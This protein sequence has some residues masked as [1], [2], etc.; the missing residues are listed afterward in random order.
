MRRVERGTSD[1]Q[2]ESVDDNLGPLNGANNIAKSITIAALPGQ[3]AFVVV[4]SNNV[5]FFVA[6]GATDSITGGE[7]SHECEYDQHDL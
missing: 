5:G 4:A 2:S 3:T 7:N 1:E 6:A